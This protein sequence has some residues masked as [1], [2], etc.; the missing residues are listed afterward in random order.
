MDIGT[1]ALVPNAVWREI[2]SATCA[3]PCQS[4]LD[5]SAWLDGERIC[6]REVP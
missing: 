2:T 1:P 4:H 5:G 3:Q 6:W